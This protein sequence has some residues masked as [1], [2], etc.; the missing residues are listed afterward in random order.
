MYDVESQG[1]VNER[2]A[3]NWFRHFKEG[4]H[5][6]ENEPRSERLSVA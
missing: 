2:V 6:L 4:E 1:T 5:S 3:Q